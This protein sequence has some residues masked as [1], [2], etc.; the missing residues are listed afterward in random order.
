MVRRYWKIYSTFFKTSFARELQFRA[1]F[2]AKILQ[3]M[4]WFGFFL[5]ILFV[6]YG[7]VKTVAGWDQRGAQILGATLYIVGSF[8]NLLTYSVLE[9]PDH[10]R[11]G[12][13]DF[14]IT[15]P[16]DSQFWISM[17]KFNFAE[18]GSL[19]GGVTL[20]VIS[21]IGFHPFP[22]AYQFLLYVI[23][24][25]CAAVNLYGFQLLLM[26][27]G[28]YF[29]RIDNLWV[30]G[31]TITGLGRY[32]M[33]IYPNGLRFLLSFVLPVAF[34]SYFPSLQLV[35]GANPMVTIEGVLISAAFFLLSRLWWRYSMRHYSSASS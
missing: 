14:I 5:V 35:N 33:D 6:V 34:F 17:R 16:V 28:I 32:P 8:S 27:T 18:I 10:V 19:L 20:V 3:N 26:T 1:N 2:I 9:I 12:T 24:V 22:S 29:I 4:T 11:N 21:L 13:L 31:E 30:L 7:Q 23:G 15:K 25:I